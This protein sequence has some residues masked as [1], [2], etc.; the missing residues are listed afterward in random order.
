LIYFGGLKISM[1]NYSRYCLY[2]AAERNGTSRP[3]STF[4]GKQQKELFSG[5]IS[6]AITFNHQPT[7]ATVIPAPVF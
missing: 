1:K 2:I 7:E 5:Y 6:T 3:S 4:Y